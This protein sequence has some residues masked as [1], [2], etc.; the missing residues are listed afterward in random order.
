VTFAALFLLGDPVSHSL[1][2]EMHSRAMRWAGARGAFVPIRV[3]ARSVGAS[4]EALARLGFLGGNVTVPHKERVLP[5]LGR[6]TGRA[7]EIG[8]VNV[9]A[10]RASRGRRPGGGY[11][12]DNTDGQGFL[13]ALRLRAGFA[14]RG[15]RVLVVGAGGA[16]RAVLHAVVGA[17]AREVV[18]LNRSAARSR[19]LA[20]AA[21]AWGGATRVA[22]GPLSAARDWARPRGGERFDLIVNATTVGLRGERSTVVPQAVIAAARVVADLPYGARETHLVRSARRCGAR[23][24]DGLDVLVGQGR[25]SFECWF[26]VV[27]PWETLAREVRAAW[28]RRLRARG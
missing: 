11:E 23:V 15:R 22:D 6:V 8:A 27:P 1:S 14:V 25:L 13:D 5:L 21:R 28:S 24:V 20:R 9:L 2:P 7:R 19:S 16:A 4:L 10:S 17:G 3:G 26:G 12:G 18:V